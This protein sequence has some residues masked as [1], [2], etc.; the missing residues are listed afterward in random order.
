MQPRDRLDR[1]DLIEKL[2]RVTEAFPQA[3]VERGINRNW[4]HYLFLLKN[5]APFWSELPCGAQICDIG[6]GAAIIP[7][8]MAQLGFSVSLVDRWSEYAREFNNQMGNAED[9]CALFD[10]LGA[11]YCTRDVLS[12]AIPLPDASQDMVSAFAVMEHLPKPRILL[13]EMK[14]L[15]KPGGTLVVTTP[16][17]AHLRNRVRL[18]LGQSPYGHPCLDFYDDR[19]FGHYRELTR[20]EI[21]EVFVREGYQVLLFKMSNSSQ[22]NTKLTSEKWEK[23]WKLNSLSQLV[24]GLYLLIVALVPGLRFDMLLVARKPQLS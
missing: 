18:M 22:T 11:R 17:C 3:V 8:V 16:N 9:F 1:R 10:K 4:N 5:L 19:F 7:L 14:R 21:R 13:N 24:R 6:S 2:R 20:N 15:L 12:E 23:E